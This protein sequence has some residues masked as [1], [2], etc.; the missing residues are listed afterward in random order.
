VKYLKEGSKWEN[1]FSS[2]EKYFTIHPPPIEKCLNGFNIVINTY[3]FVLSSTHFLFQILAVIISPHNHGLIPK[4][5]NF[6][7]ARIWKCFSQKSPTF[8]LNK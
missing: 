1:I 6:N 2:I 3:L 5:H 7:K 4:L 8:T